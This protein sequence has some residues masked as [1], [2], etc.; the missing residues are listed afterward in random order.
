MNRTNQSP[1]NH[2]LREQGFGLES[3]RFKTSPMVL[4][5]SDPTYFTTRLS[6]FPAT[7]TTFTTVFPDICWAIASTA[8]AAASMVA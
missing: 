5:G 7:Y 6:S 4:D 2:S 3:R 8:C 1:V